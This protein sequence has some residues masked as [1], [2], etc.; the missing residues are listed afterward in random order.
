MYQTHVR[1]YIISSINLKKVI[2][3]YVF[4]NTDILSLWFNFLLMK[5]NELEHTF[6]F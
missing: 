6:D 3:S 4:I 2:S 1:N 5:K